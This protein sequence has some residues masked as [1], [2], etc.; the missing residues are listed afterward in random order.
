VNSGL[1]PYYSKEKK[2]YNNTL[3]AKHYRHAII[4]TN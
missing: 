4:F 1:V 3:E 2:L